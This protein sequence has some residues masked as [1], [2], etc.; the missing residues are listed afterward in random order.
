MQLLLGF[1]TIPFSRLLQST[2]ININITERETA[3]W[4]MPRGM[5]QRGKKDNFIMKPK[6][7]FNQASNYRFTEIVELQYNVLAI[8]EYGIVELDKSRI[9]DIQQ[10]KW[11]NVF[12]Q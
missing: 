10:N 8:P 9:W 4:F 1:P 12:Y 7:E 2:P 11:I 3:G 5:V 6:S